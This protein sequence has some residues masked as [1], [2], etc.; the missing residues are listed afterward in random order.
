[1]TPGR[2]GSSGFETLMEAARFAYDSG[3]EGNAARI[4]RAAAERNKSAGNI[5]GELEARRWAGNALMWSGQHTAALRA[6]LPVATSTHPQADP[7]SVYGAKT[8]CIMLALSHATA[9]ACASMLDETRAYLAGLGKLHWEHRLELLR[10]MLLYR[11]GRLPD[12]VNTGL[13]AYRLRC[14]CGDG[15]AYSDVAHI[16]WIVRPLFLLKAESALDEWLRLAEEKRTGMV[17]DQVFVH[18]I[19][20][21]A[22]RLRCAS[23]AEPVGLREEARAAAQL[24]LRQHALAYEFF[25]IGRAM[26]LAGQWHDLD[27]RVKDP[28]VECPFQRAL[29]SV[30]RQINRLRVSLRLPAWDPDLDR[31]EPLPSASRSRVQWPAA[32]SRRLTEQLTTLERAAEDED[33]RLETTFYTAMAQRRRQHARALERFITPS[34]A[35]DTT[36]SESSL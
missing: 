27:T 7:A 17:S 21:L 29:F 4:Y 22:L 24:I 8:D 36:T 28:V 10:S 2:I 11:Q 32:E 31:P 25:E 9:T 15:P 33:R 19:R 5:T 18:C 30:D 14:A 3:C 13:R 1:M 26:M 20:L 35:A 34:T 16:K 12:A 23:G 6:L